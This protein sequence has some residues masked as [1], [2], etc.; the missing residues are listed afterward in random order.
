MSKHI[1][2]MN[3]AEVTLE[4]LKTAKDIP[5]GLYSRAKY[6]A[7]IELQTYDKDGNLTF[8]EEF[9]KTKD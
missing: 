2:V 1:S 3:L 5:D 8:V 6:L 4:I 9:L 7:S